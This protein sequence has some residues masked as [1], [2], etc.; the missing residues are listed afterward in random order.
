RI[1]QNAI[2]LDK[3][4][5]FSNADRA[6]WLHIKLGRAWK[7]RW[8]VLND[9]VLYYLKTNNPSSPVQGTFDLHVYTPRIDPA[10]RKKG[11]RW[12]IFLLECPG[13][14]VSIKTESHRD[15]EAWVHA[16]APPKTEPKSIRS[17]S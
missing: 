2:V 9:N 1:V 16:I 3:D 13:S 8:F 7:R 4:N 11:S 17:S 14:S 12:F 6:G 5:V 15:Q 10:P